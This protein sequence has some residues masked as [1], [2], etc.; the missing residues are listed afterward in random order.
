MEQMLE[1]RH[2]SREFRAPPL[3]QE[4]LHSLFFSSAIETDGGV[5][6]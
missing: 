3:S 4:S 1:V 2:P 5:A 6:T